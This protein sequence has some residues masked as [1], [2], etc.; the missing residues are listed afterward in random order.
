MIEINFLP[1]ELRQ[2]E[3]LKAA[4]PEIPIKKTLFIVFGGVFGLQ[5]FFT[6]FTFY[7]RFDMTIV[8]K[9][10]QGL[11]ESSGEITRQK[12]ETIGIHNRVKESRQLAAREFYWAL[13][14]NGLS[15]SMTQ[16]VWLRALRVTEE[17]PGKPLKQEKEPAKARYLVLEGSAVGSGQETA[18]IGK[19]LKQLKDNPLFI[20]LFQDISPTHINQ[21]RLKEFD[22]YDFTIYCKFR[23]N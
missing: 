9:Q 17:G 2:K 14:L 19:F 12:S 3:A 23:K 21:R 8:A 4:L 6:L 1:E 13:L 5:L 10:I 11:K 7:L 16:G 22:V 18:F 20:N 15:N